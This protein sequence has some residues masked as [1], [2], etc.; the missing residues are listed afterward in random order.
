[1]GTSNLFFCNILPGIHS[2]KGLEGH[3]CFIFMVLDVNNIVG[4][5]KLFYVWE[6]T[7]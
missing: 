4:F 3:L 5:L 7:L 1:M 2:I 6:K